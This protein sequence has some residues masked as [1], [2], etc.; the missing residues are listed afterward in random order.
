[1]RRVTSAFAV[2]WLIVTGVLM[3]MVGALM[4]WENATDTCIGFSC[5]WPMLMVGLVVGA[6]GAAYVAAGVGLWR[7]RW[8]ARG[9]GVLRALPGFLLAPLIWTG[10]IYGLVRAVVPYGE[11]PDVGWA[12][13][14]VPVLANGVAMA[15]VWLSERDPS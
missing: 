7:G 12:T 13:V 14:L 8:W 1:V 3:L 15:G 10:L 11:P 9:A 2:I 5:G 6:F 4:A